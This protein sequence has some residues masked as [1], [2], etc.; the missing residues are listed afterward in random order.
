MA[1]RKPENTRRHLCHPM[2]VQQAGLG[3]IL[4]MLLIT[5][6]GMATSFF[7]GTLGPFMR[8]AVFDQN[9]RSVSSA[10]GGTGAGGGPSLLSPHRWL[11]LEKTCM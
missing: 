10:S 1:V 4:A 5:A 6:A 8:S 7:Q 9:S 2:A 3:V 11:F